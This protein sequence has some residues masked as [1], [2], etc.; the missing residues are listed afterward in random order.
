[1]N[2]RTRTPGIKPSAR[3]KK[4]PQSPADR[5]VL[6]G[7]EAVLFYQLSDLGVTASDG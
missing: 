7:F 4:P 6:K 1:M 3:S 5:D 2:P